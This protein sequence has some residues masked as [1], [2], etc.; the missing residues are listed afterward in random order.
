MI[1]F[2]EGFDGVSVPIVNWRIGIANGAIDPV[3]GRIKSLARFSANPIVNLGPSGSWDDTT[4]Q[5]PSAIRVGN[6]MW[7]YYSGND[8]SAFRV[9]RAVANIL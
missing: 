6:E 4:V 9:G 3:D 5:L 1:V 7:V 8:G 2:Y